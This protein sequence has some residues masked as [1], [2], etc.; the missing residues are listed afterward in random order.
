MGKQAR[1]RTRSVID[2][3][4]GKTRG[5]NDRLRGQIGVNTIALRDGCTIGPP[6]ESEYAVEPVGVDTM[7]PSDWYSH[8]KMRLWNAESKY[9]YHRFREVLTVD[10]HVDGV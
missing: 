10:E 7:R 9:T 2:E 4:D 6:A 3:E 8:M 1:K 5:R